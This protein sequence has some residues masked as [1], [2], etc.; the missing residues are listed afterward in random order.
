MPVVGEAT[1][2]TTTPL[3]CPAVRYLRGKK[4]VGS[5]GLEADVIMEESK[6]KKKKKQHSTRK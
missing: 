2:L 3:H 5:T 6:L 4:N 1:V